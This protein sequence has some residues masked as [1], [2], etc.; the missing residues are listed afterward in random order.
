MSS[1][2]D[3][4]RAEYARYRALAEGAIRQLDAA[5]L[6]V[7]DPGDNSISTLVWHLSGNVQSRFTDFLTTDGEK[8][9]RQRD[10]EFAPRS[11]S[12]S[13]LMERWD[14]GWTVLEG[15]VG[16]LVEADLNRTITIRSQPLLVH[17]A[18]LR[19]LAHAAYHV[20]QIVLRAKA[21]QGEAWVSLSIPPGGSVAYNAAPTSETASAH[22]VRLHDKSS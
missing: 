14:A 10:D 11:V 17:Q 3:S 5:A 7:A 16:E 8:P 21:A 22:A 1:V 12:R 20:G 18:L 19:S 4:I 6:C 9:W 2:L 15:A 13:E